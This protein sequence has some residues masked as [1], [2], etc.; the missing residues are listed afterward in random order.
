MSAIISCTFH[1]FLLRHRL[2]LGVQLH[3]FCHFIL[4]LCYKTSSTRVTSTNLPQFYLVILLTFAFFVNLSSTRRIY[5]NPRI[6]TVS[7]SKCHRSMFAI[8]RIF[9]MLPVDRES[10]TCRHIVHRPIL[11]H[12]NLASANTIVTRN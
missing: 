10:L 8:M 11:W 12:I 1:F 3:S 2:L 5:L 9:R 6:H 4:S 7:M